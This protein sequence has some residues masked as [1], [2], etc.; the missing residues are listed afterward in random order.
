MSSGWKSYLQYL[1]TA[2]PDI[3]DGKAGR[4]VFVTEEDVSPLRR[5]TI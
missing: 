3:L 2:E 1:A 5:R 4:S